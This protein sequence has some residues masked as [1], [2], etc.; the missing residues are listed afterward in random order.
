MPVHM[1]FE[2]LL[3]WADGEHQCPQTAPQPEMAGVC[4]ASASIDWRQLE[5]FLAFGKRAGEVFEGDGVVLVLNELDRFERELTF[6]PG[7][8][9]DQTIRLHGEDVVG[10]VGESLPKQ[11]EQFVEWQ[12]DVDAVL[13]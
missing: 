12:T 9:A 5:P 2:G 7:E 4:E 3:R 13:R 8:T 11:G 10:T 1:V 6:G